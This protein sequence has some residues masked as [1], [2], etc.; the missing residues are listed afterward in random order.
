[1][2]EGVA[3]ASTMSCAAELC[4]VP[5]VDALDDPVLDLLLDPGYATATQRNGLR[6]G[7]IGDVLVDG[8]SAQAGGLG[9]VSK[10]D[11]AHGFAPVWLVQTIRGEGSFLLAEP[12]LS[13]RRCC[14]WIAR[15]SWM[16]VLPSVGTVY[17]YRGSYAALLHILSNLYF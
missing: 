13:K 9:D 17:G 8:G 11:E 10:S 6:E 16:S 14:T 12:S 2:V 4:G 3:P 1:M 5:C 7:A 15:L